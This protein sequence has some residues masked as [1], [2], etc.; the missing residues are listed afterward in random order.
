MDDFGGIIFVVVL[1][2]LVI[3]AI[4][5]VIVPI[6]AVTAGAGTCLGAGH[7]IAN[8]AKSFKDNMGKR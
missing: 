2:A 4:V 5:Y 1:I 6:V 7:C 8:Y 3:A